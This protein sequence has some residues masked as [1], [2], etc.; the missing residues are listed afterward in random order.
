M[1]IKLTKRIAAI[2]MDRGESSIRINPTALAEAKKAITREDV[3]VL[4]KNGSVYAIKEKKNLSL[5]GKELKKKRIA[6]RKRGYGR[7]KGTKN[8]RSGTSLYPKKIRGQ[9]RILKSL[10][11]DKIIDNI[12]FKKYY[13]LTKGGSFPTKISLINH[14]KDSGV[15]INDELM[16][17]LKHI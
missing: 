11:N 13:K 7:R 3:R 8:A 6:G 10:K 2:V 16:E 15:K 4:I 1:S 9:R 5:H 17:K 12:V 14:I